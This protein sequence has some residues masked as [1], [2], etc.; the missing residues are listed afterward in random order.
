LQTASN[1]ELLP[2]NH[3][4]DLVHTAEPDEW[5]VTVD[6]ERV[7]TFSGPSAWTKALSHK[8]ELNDLLSH[9]S[10]EDPLAD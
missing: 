4:V 2:S 10:A 1:V 7:L 6:G 3:K 5:C 8:A 9:D